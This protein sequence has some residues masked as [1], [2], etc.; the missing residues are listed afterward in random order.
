M[1]DSL[2]ELRS[3][4]RERGFPLPWALVR[5]FPPM[6]VRRSWRK[7][8]G[9][10]AI[11]AESSATEARIGSSRISLLDWG[12]VVEVKR[13]Q[14]VTVA[15]TEKEIERLSGIARRIPLDTPS[16]QIGRMIG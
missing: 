13:L 6:Q 16:W 5:T 12:R 11:R 10:F 7:G 15:E 8:F 1:P 14:G 3:Y 9:R 4:F 2:D